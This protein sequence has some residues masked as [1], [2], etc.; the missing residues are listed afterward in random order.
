MFQ[1]WACKQVLGIASTNGWVS[2]WDPSVDGL[3][4]SCRQCTETSEHVLYCNENG[5]VDAMLQSVDSLELWLNKT[6]TDPELTSCLVQYA[7]GRRG[8][9]MQTI[10][11][12]QD[13]SLQAMARSQ[14]VIGWRRFMEGMISR[15]IVERQRDHL[16][17]KGIQWQLN[18]WASGLVVR[19]LEITHGQWLYRNVV[20]HDRIGQQAGSRWCARNGFWRTLKSNRARERKDC[21]R[22]TD[23]S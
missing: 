13:S 9:A 2:K 11:Q 6:D 15:R 23:I 3:C 16:R 1:L 4:P 20:V 14:D 19:L 22:S 5:R 18:R 21:W 8:V 12:D 7:R 10:C 17:C